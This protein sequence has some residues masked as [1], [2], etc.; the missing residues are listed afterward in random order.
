MLGN[1]FFSINHKNELLDNP[2]GL[3]VEGDSSLAIST[4][5]VFLDAKAGM[6]KRFLPDLGL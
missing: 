2:T 6:D 5:N 4:W 3:S 1:E